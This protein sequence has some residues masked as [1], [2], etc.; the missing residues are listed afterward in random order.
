M[1][2]E[3]GTSWFTRGLPFLPVVRPLTAPA[4]TL[5]SSLQ[6]TDA[7]GAQMQQIKLTT[8]AVRTMAL[9]P[10]TAI[11]PCIVRHSSLVDLLMFSAFGHPTG[12]SLCVLMCSPGNTTFCQ[13]RAYRWQAQAH[14]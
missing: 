8:L 1:H 14:Q 6:A 3:S 5:F 9:P 2:W 12:F 7:E 10:G 4:C 11:K 13:C